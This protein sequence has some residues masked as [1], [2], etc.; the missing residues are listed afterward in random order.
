VKV[1]VALPFDLDSYH[2]HQHNDEQVQ[3]KAIDDAHAAD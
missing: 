1:N 2:D 3:A